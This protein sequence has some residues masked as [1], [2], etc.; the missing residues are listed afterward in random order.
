MLINR[1]QIN[2]ILVYLSSG[3]TTTEK[4]AQLLATIVT[5]NRE[6]GRAKISEKFNYLD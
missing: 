2:A 6:L 4:T 3:E 5:G 1:A